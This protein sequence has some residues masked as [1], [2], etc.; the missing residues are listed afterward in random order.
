M[1]TL[2]SK[3]R[4]FLSSTNYEFECL[5]FI[6]VDEHGGPRQ[7]HGHHRRQAL[8]ARNESGF[9]A[10]LLQ[11]LAGVRHVRCTPVIK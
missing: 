10:M 9:A 3:M 11:Q 5:N 6:N 1:E 2:V 4:G 8:P 7:P